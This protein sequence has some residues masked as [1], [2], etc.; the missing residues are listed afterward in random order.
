MYGE[1]GVPGWLFYLIGESYTIMRK[2]RVSK[3]TVRDAP[4]AKR[5]EALLTGT[6]LQGTLNAWNQIGLK[7]HYTLFVLTASLIKDHGQ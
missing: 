3:A 4:W 2:K 5:D 6:S 7:G 1:K